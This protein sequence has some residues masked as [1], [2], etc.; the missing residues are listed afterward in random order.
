MNRRNF[1]TM[2]GVMAATGLTSLEAAGQAAVTP[3]KQLANQKGLIFG[4]SLAL[5]YFS[6]S[7]AYEKLFVDEC[8][9][10]TPELHMKWNSLNPQPGFY[11]F[12]AADQLVG[13]CARH[14]MKV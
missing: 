8:N 7:S 14:N 11:D 4:S 3:L 1:L 13:F 9:I 6:Q 10:A 12:S 5:K 2:L